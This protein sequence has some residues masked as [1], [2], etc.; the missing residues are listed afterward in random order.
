MIR[1]D[2]TSVEQYTYEEFESF[3]KGIKRLSD[4]LVSENPDY[5][6]A[7]VVGSVP[8]IDLVYIAN[9][10]FD[11]DKVEYPPNSSRFF[12]REKLI[13]QWISGF[14]EE[15]YLGEKMRIFCLDEVISGAST[16]K[17]YQEFQKAVHLFEKKIGER[18]G[19]KISYK[20]LGIAEKPR[21]RTRNHTIKSL[22]NSKKAKLVEVKR[23]LTA[24]NVDLNHVRLKIQRDNY[25]GR[26][27]YE[28]QI[29]KFYISK[30]YLT[31]LQNM[32]SY[33]GADSSKV[34]A[35]NLGKI[36]NSLEKYL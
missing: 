4:I 22:V 20:I 17:G 5:V 2:M 25:R 14:L 28:P 32:A 8:L 35:Q 6:F 31:L 33:F 18:L 26:H 12:D 27:I 29:D 34:T 7:P 36:R 24:D 9:R 3:A 13:S 21:D 10:H 30:E 15:K 11:L 19:R 16:V 23:I 1:I